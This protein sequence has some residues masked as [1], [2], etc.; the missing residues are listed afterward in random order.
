M[1]SKHLPLE[2]PLDGARELAPS[3][4]E[5]EHGACSTAPFLRIHLTRRCVCACALPWQGILGLV[6]GCTVAA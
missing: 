1:V 4:G 6:S 2:D 5:L 3:I